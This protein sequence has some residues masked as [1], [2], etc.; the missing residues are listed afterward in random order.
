MSGED[1]S[2][3]SPRLCSNSVVEGCGFGALSSASFDSRRG[4]CAAA[5]QEQLMVKRLL[6]REDA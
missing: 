6:P 4:L 5:A 3:F 1:Q 2:A